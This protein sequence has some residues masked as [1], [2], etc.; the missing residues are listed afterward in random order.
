[1]TCSNCTV[2][3]TTT[4]YKSYLFGKD[5]KL[6]ILYIH[7][8]LL[9]ADNT[10]DQDCLKLYLIMHSSQVSC[11]QLSIQLNSKHQFAPS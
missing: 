5:V 3:T 6:F 7:L 1:M 11:V 4:V 8:P 10:S 2:Y 9:S